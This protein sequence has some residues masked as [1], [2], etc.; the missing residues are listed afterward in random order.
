MDEVVSEIRN[1]CLKKETIPFNLDIF[2][3]PEASPAEVIRSSRSLPV[4]SEKRVVIVKG[5][6]Q[7]NAKA[8]EG[9]LAYLKDPV[10]TTCLLLL[11]GKIDMR[12]SFAKT[13]KTHG[14]AIEVKRLSEGGLR[15]WL[16]RTAARNGKRINADAV[17]FIVQH[18]NRELSAI[19]N[20][21]EKILSFCEDSEEID[22]RNVQEVV[23]DT[24]TRNVFEFINMLGRKQT[25]KALDVLTRMIEEGAA[26]LMI[27]TMVARQFR[28]IW[29]AKDI[30]NRGGKKREIAGKLKLTP[31]QARPLLAQ[32]DAF[33]VDELERA[34]RLFL[35]I[36]GA[37]K[38][39]RL[40]RGFAL[41]MM[42]IKLC[43]SSQADYF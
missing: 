34:F 29:G 2:H 1:K 33:S 39:S 23:S 3:A 30:L 38:S 31:Y 19:S 24:R 11:C 13:V 42:T 27:L 36:D 14:L 28:L 22:L 35:Q 7:W 18:C 4:M 8:L 6:S 5:A 25:L 43:G 32:L 21:F 9:F 10:P 40:S 16:H 37:L 17:S 41:E 12:L 15:N 26:P 20:E